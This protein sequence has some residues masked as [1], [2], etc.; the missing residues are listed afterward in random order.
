MPKPNTATAP[1]LRS[2]LSGMCPVRTGP[3]PHPSPLFLPNPM[4]TRMLGEKQPV[5][6]LEAKDLHL[7]ESSPL[8]KKQSTYS[9]STVT[10]SPSRNPAPNSTCAHQLWFR[11]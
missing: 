11:P 4:K 10:A 1:Q 5:Q 7:L 9:E 2:N 3:H 6:P 8:P